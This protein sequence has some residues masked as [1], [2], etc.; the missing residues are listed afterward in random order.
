[1]AA[2]EKIF[3]AKLHS[4]I[5]GNLNRSALVMQSGWRDTVLGRN[6]FPFFYLT[7]SLFSKTPAIEQL[8]KNCAARKRECDCGTRSTQWM[9]IFIRYCGGKKADYSQL[10]PSFSSCW[11]GRHKKMPPSNLA[12]MAAYVL[13]HKIFTSIE[14]ISGYC[15][16]EIQLTDAF[17]TWWSIMKKVFAYKVQGMRLRY[18]YPTRLG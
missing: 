14:E 2:T 13:S 11:K 10:I 8:I 7:T 16:G 18:W 17:H 1:M 5:Y 12:I 9:L 15:S 4:P 6:I 3:T